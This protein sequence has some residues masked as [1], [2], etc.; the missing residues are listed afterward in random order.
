M[1]TARAGAPRLSLGLDWTRREALVPY[2]FLLP[3]FVALAVVFFYPMLRAVVLSFHANAFGAGLGQFV[4][5]SQYTAIAASPYFVRVLATSVLWTVGNVVFV[6]AIGMITALM[7]DRR[8]PARSVVRALFILPWA[9]P[10]VAAALT[11]GWILDY[12]F[13][14][15][16]YLAVA[17]GLAAHKLNFLLGCPDALISLTSVSVW[18][19][20]PLGTVMFLAGLQ[21]IPAEYYE[22]AKVDG[23]SALQSFLYVTLPGVRNVT[24]MAVESALPDP[25][26]RL[27]I[28][29]VG[30]APPS[31]IGR[32]HR[33][34]ARY[35]DRF[36]IA[37]GVFSSN[38]DANRDA[39]RELRLSPDRTYADVRSMIEC[40][41][42]R[43]D[44]ID[45]VA[46]LTPNGSHFEIAKQFAEQDFHI[47]CE[48]PVTTRVADA[49]DLIEIQKQR[50]RVFV[51][52]HAY[53]GYT[54]VRHARR[55]IRD[56]VLGRLR[57]VQV[58]YVQGWLATAVER[59]G[60]K[61]ARNR[62]DPEQNGSAGCLAAIGSHAF[63]LAEYVTGLEL[64]TVSANLKTFVPGRAVPDNAHLLLRYGLGVTGAM[65]QKY[66]D[67]GRS[68]V[69]L[70]T[71][72]P[73]CRARSSWGSGGKP[74]IASIL[75]SASSWIASAV[76]GVTN[77]MSLS[78]SSPTYA[79]MLTTT[80]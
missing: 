22:A 49:I 21:T 80:M 66:W 52:A 76:A 26:R 29:F 1:S 13:G 16:N 75:P 8:F 17:T 39:G 30:G 7:L 20:F 57:V 77:V 62:T 15:L 37:G 3:S 79:A 58:E 33:I 67:H 11:W 70:I 48:K 50:Q 34:A 60:D 12:E 59:T 35:D 41:R 9:I 28:G 42:H 54:M 55:L 2:A 45:L 6:L 43:Q 14:V 23:A 4:G 25:P 47:L 18:K 27:R 78:G 61:V 44:R 32:V 24:I 56:G 31:F 68:V 63:N 65:Q 73:I 36:E 40:E 74:I 53:T 72:W 10:Y 71:T 38:A 64:E 51:V 5:F 69:V 19:L 46:I